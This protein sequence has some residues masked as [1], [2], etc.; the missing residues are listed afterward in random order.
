[1]LI[2]H[3][4]IEKS[5]EYDGSQI[6]SSWAFKS[7]GIKGS[8]ILTWRGPMN[9]KK[10]NLKDFE[11]IGTEIKSNDMLHFIIEHFDSQPANLRLAYLRQRLLVMI[12]AEELKKIGIDSKRKG[13][14]I[15]INSKKLTVSIA[16]A[17]ISSIKIHFGINITSKG[18]PNDVETIGLFEINNSS[19]N[20]KKNQKQ[21]SIIY[22]N[23]N[24][25]LPFIKNVVNSY[26]N[27]LT[28]IELD[29]SKTDLL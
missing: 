8:S 29:I 23:E 10:T 21:E 17:S 6:E 20:I 26:I 18:T 2:V 9:I 16:T 22:F 27:E 5:F 15:F 3:K 7:F 19:E 25:L 28:D 14:D 4:H 13:D 24:N 11:D 1:M 12:F